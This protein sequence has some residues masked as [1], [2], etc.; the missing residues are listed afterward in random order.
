MKTTEQ[1]PD[2]KMQL[3]ALNE[4]PVNVKVKVTVPVGVL[5][6]VVVSATVATTVAVQL[7][8]PNNMVQLTA[9]TLVEVLSFT[10]VI[11]PEVPA[12]PL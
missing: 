5:A 8:A 11:A 9:G 2:T 3:G 12:L 10:T 1:L 7:V 6:G 4:P